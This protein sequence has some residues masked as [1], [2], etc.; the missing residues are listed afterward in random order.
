MMKKNNS[1]PANV[2]KLKR[3]LDKKPQNV[4]AFAKVKERVDKKND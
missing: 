1:K 3:V 2:I 4:I